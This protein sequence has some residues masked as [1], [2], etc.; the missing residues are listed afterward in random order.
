[1]KIQKVHKDLFERVIVLDD[2]EHL[3]DEHPN[4]SI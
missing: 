1:M 4:D 2:T 3:Q